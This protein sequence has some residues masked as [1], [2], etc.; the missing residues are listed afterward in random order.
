VLDEV[1]V[2]RQGHARSVARLAVGSERAPVA[3]RRQAGERERQDVGAPPTAGIGDEADAA[4][5][6]L[7]ARVVE[8]DGGSTW[9]RWLRIDWGSGNRWMDGRPAPKRRPAS[10][11]SA[12]VSGVMKS[13]ATPQDW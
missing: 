4:R 1:A 10:W 8:G 2:E 6:V 5:V 3:E 9:H 13:E 7:V 12:A 11:R